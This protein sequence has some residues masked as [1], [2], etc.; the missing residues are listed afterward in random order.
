MQLNELFG[1]P[2]DGQVDNQKNAYYSHRR[3]N[4]GKLPGRLKVPLATPPREN[5]RKN[6]RRKMAE[7]T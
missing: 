5:G 6:N 7:K 3:G 4:A 2:V 1:I